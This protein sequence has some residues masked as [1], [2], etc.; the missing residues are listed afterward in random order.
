M[1]TT[2]EDSDAPVTTIEY[3][4]PYYYSEG[5]KWINTNTTIY[6]NAT[7]MSGVNYTHYEIW[8]DADDD[9]DFETQIE[10]YTVYDNTSIDEDQSSSNIS[11]HTSI[12]GPCHHKITAYSVDIFGNGEVVFRDDLFLQWNYSFQIN[13]DHNPRGILPFGSSP[14]I[15]NILPAT[16]NMEIVCGSDE[17]YN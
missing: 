17:T 2:S 5:N 1:E 12:S 14:A 4:V 13:I 9:G 10:V 8:K 7:D 3:G 6:I 16:E 15:A 11:I